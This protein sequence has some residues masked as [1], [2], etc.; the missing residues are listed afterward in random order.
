M[1]TSSV[2]MRTLSCALTSRNPRMPSFCTM[3]TSGW[4]R[5][6]PETTFIWVGK[7]ATQDEVGV[8]AYKTVELD[9]SLGKF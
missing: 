5:L 7:E 1:E 3:S 2:A 6:L 9:D 4:V 8:A